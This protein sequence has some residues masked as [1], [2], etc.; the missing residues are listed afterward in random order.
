MDSRT[1]A[2]PARGRPPVPGPGPA[3]RASPT[4][5]RGFCPNPGATLAVTLLLAVLA[6]WWTATE[7]EAQ[8]LNGEWDVRWAQAVRVNADGTVEVQRWGDASLALQHSGEQ[9]TGTWTTEVRERVTWAVTGTVRD[10]RLLLVATEHDSANDELAVVER[11]TW[12]AEVKDDRLEGH[13]MLVIR[14]RQR[15]PGR[16]PFTAARSEND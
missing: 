13:V 7:A 15:E 8:D 3:P 10:G 6:P 11:I 5:G 2:G 14:G 4:R 9:V 1:S 12:Q 16:R